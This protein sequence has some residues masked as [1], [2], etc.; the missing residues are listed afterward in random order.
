LPLSRGVRAVAGDLSE[1]GA[2]G[3]LFLAGRIILGVYYLSSAFN[4]FTHFGQ[5]TAYTAAHHVPLPGLAVAASAVLLLVAGICFLLGVLPR[6]GVA[7]AVLFLVPVSVLMHAFW[8]DHDPAMRMNDLVNFTK[9]MGL[10][11]STLMFLGVPEPWP[12]SVHIQSHRRVRV[13]V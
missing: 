6:V 12:Y 4:H 2:M 8:S 11:G 9:N 3:Q 13:R 7:A 1:E 10:V 5:M